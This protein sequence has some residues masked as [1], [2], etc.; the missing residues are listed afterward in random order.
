M[1][2]SALAAFALTAALL[3]ACGNEETRPA[4]PSPTIAPPRLPPNT[5]PLDWP[6]ASELADRAGCVRA[7]DTPDLPVFIAA[8]QDCLDPAW[9]VKSETPDSVPDAHVS[10]YVFNNNDGRDAWIHMAG[11]L[12]DHG[13]VRGDRWAVEIPDDLPHLDQVASTVATLLKGVRVL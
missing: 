5:L 11:T 4:A 7:V 6:S 3:A 1:K 9:T 10:F 2:R 13:V 12:G 8:G